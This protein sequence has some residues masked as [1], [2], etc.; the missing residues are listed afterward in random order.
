MNASWRN[1]AAC[2]GIDAEIF[3]PV[4]DEDAEAAKAVCNVCPV[5][6]ACLEF[7][8]AAREREGVWGGATE[9]ERRRI[10]RQRRKTA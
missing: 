9:R 1:R 4:T 2:R 6:E 8:L 10:V 5:R 7:A 3:F